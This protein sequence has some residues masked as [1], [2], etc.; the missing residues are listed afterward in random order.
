MK[1]LP[2]PL[3]ILKSGRE[4]IRFIREPH[5]DLLAIRPG[6]GRYSDPRRG[7]VP[8]KDLFRVLYAGRDPRAAFE[9]T[10][11]R[12]RRADRTGKTIFSLAELAHWRGGSVRPRRDLRLVDL[13]DVGGS[14]RILGTTIDE[15]KGA[16]YH[17]T[18]YYSLAFHEHPIQPDGIVYTSRYAGTP[19]IAIYERAG[20]SAIDADV[21][22]PIL[23]FELAPIFRKF[24]IEVVVDEA[25]DE[26]D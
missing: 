6:S 13:R 7:A 9:E 4:F 26:G 10:V 21:S 22:R 1:G 8:G 16:S 15:L 14:W 20:V 24:G 18:Q 17:A 3:L 19:C 2:L 11:L 12:D 5:R 23:E 25:E